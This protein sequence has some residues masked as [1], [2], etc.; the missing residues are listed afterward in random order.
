MILF[1]FLFF[2]FWFFKTGFLCSS[3]CP[4]THSV[5][6]AGLQLTECRQSAGTEDVCLNLVK[7]SPFRNSLQSVDMHWETL[8]IQLFLPSKQQLSRAFK[9]PVSPD[10]FSGFP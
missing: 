4:E 5:D 10:G 9:V 8:F 1:L 6:Q 3:G 7:E 2:G